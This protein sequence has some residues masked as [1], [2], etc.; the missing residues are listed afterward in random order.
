LAKCVYVW[1][2]TVQ[3]ASVDEVTYFEGIFVQARTMQSGSY[4]TGTFDVLGDSQLLVLTC[5]NT[6]SD[7]RQ[8]RLSL[9]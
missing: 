9:F 5:G 2:F 4:D 8:S 7:V 6:T 1:R 3:V